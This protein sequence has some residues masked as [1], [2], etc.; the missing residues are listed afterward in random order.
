MS[1]PPDALPTP[2]PSMRSVSEGEVSA[3]RRTAGRRCSATVGVG[4]V[5]GADQVVDV[6]VRILAT[7]VHAHGVLDEG[8]D[9]PR[10]L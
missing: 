8:L 2:K 3:G 10:D 5:E 7:E 6:H 4:S 1:R 9:L